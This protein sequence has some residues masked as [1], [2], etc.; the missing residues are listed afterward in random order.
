MQLHSDLV[1][2]CGTKSTPLSLTPKRF[3]DETKTTD[4][5]TCYD[6]VAIN[7]EAGLKA[8]LLAAFPDGC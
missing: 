8:V 6:A 2:S 7:L 5:T 3:V 1:I 4:Q